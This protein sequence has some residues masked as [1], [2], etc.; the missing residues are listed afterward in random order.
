MER[1]LTFGVVPI[2]NENDTVATDEIRYGDNDRL[3]AQIAA[4]VSADNLILLS[5][6]DGLYSS[7]PLTNPE[8]KRLDIIKE[9]TRKLKEMAGEGFRVFL[10]WNDNKTYGGSNSYA[11]WLRYGNYKGTFPIR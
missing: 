4:T 10:R 7:N 6:V 3:A 9:I 8:A 11:G 1:L 5:D 2:V